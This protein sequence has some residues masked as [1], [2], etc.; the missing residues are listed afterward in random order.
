M[1]KCYPFWKGF[2]LQRFCFSQVCLRVRQLCPGQAPGLQMVPEVL[3]VK[4]RN[5]WLGCR[6]YSSRGEMKS[7]SRLWHLVTALSAL[8]GALVFRLLMEEQEEAVAARGWERAVVDMDLLKNSFG[9][10]NWARRQEK[11]I[12]IRFKQRWQ[13]GTGLANKG[14]K[15]RK[16]TKNPR[17]EVRREWRTWNVNTEVVRNRIWICRG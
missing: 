6:K 8:G 1:K 15:G 16:S 14:R 5:S 10:E 12:E 17:L 4:S 2:T 7:C 3:Q 9:W 13:R 11:G